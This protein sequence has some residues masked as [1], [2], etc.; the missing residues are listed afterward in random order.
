MI[1]H[2]I[3]NFFALSID[4]V[5]MIERRGMGSPRQR[6][7]ERDGIAPAPQSREGWDRR[8]TEER[9]GMGSPRHRKSEKDGLAPTPHSGEG[10][11]RPDTVKRRGI[12][13]PRYRKSEKDGLAPTPH[14]GEGWDRPDT[15]KRRGILSYINKY[16][17]RPGICKLTHDRVLCVSGWDKLTRLMGS[18]RQS[19]DGWNRPG[20]T[21]FADRDGIVPNIIVRHVNISS[22]NDVCWEITF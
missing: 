10:W 14:S 2:R 9:R 8:G 11:D 21:D 12:V 13:S 18:P 3:H 5:V 22:G 6:R 20:T 1:W 17:D 16:K 4:F 7:A 15:V 19:W